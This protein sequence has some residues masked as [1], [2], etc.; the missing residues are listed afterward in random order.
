MKPE[1]LYFLTADSA[2]QEGT[3][4]KYSLIGIFDNLNM[5]S[6]GTSVVVPNFVMYFKILNSEGTENVEVEIVTPTGVSLTK[7]PIV[8]DKPTKENNLTVAVLLQNIEFE[9]E[10]EYEVKIRVNNIELT[11]VVN[12]SLSVVK[13]S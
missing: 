5:P 9:T 1:I 7:M 13:V 3:T 4:N 2:I 8:A 10:G 6:D 12:Q 11:P